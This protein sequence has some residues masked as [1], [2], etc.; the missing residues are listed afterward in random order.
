MTAI[1]VGGEAGTALVRESKRAGE[2]QATSQ[3]K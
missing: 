3:R 2:A 1:G